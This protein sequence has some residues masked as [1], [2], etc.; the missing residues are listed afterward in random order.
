[1]LSILLRWIIA[2]GLALATLGAF[3]WFAFVKGQTLQACMALGA[4]ALLVSLVGPDDDERE[5]FIKFIGAQPFEED[6]A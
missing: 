2:A 5:R 3:L 1:M 4:G 6:G